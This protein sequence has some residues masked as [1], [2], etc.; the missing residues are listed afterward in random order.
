MQREQRGSRHAVLQPATA[1]DHS[2]DTDRRAS[3]M[4]VR[5]SDRVSRPMWT[6]RMSPLI[7]LRRRDSSLLALR[8][9][10]RTALVVPALL[11]LGI[12]VIHDTEVATFAVFGSFAMLMMVDFPGPVRARVQAEAGLAVA[13]GALV[14]AGTLVSRSTV[15]AVIAMALVGF[16]LLYAGIVSSVLAGATTSLLLAFILPVSLSAPPSAIPERLA[17]WG[18]AAVAALLAVAL[19]WP[20][21]AHDHVRGA[22]IAACRAL[23]RRLH[24]HVGY[25]VGTVAEGE[26]EAAVAEADAAVEA[27]QS[28]FLQTP[29]RPTG[30][31]TSARAVVRLVDELRWLSTIVHRASPRVALDRS[32]VAV[33]T[34]TAT[35]LERSADLLDA[36]REDPAAVDAAVGGLRSRLTDLRRS[37]TRQLPLNDARDGGAA[38]DA[39]LERLVSATDPSFRAQE[40][41]FVV[42]QVA[43]NIEL[44]AA[45]E[46]RTWLEQLLGRPPAGAV[47]ALSTARERAASA[48]RRDSV[49]LQNSVRGAVG[50]AVA[51]GVASA[52]EVQHSFWVVLATLSVLRSSALGTGQNAVRGLLG[53]TVGFAVGAALVVLIGTD[54]A[55]LW[56]LLPPAVLLAGLAPANVSFAAGQAA[57]TL[58]LLILFNILAPAGWQIGLVRIEDIALGGAVSVAVGLLFW[59]RGAGG[60][61]GS[62][63]AAAYR[64][65]ADYLAG[66]VRFGIGRPHADAP[67]PG[68]PTDEA[69]RAAAAARRLDDALRTFLSERGAKP[70]PLAEV[71]SLATGVVALRL[72]GDAVLDLWGGA[73]RTDGDR[74]AARGLVLTSTEQMLDWYHAFATSLTAADGVPEPSPPDRVAA[75]RLVV[76]LGRDLDRRDDGATATAVQIVWTGDQ[77]DAARRLQ[78]MI[79]GP[80]EIAVRRHALGRARARRSGP[81]PR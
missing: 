75:R 39:P 11:G 60:A 24:T 69:T 41:S 76:A 70:V 50:L 49:W 4:I 45:A 12:E 57:F 2:A 34:A 37:A 53:T 8:R 20:A 22:A 73:E 10:A 68:A 74:T 63:L 56:A 35:L 64:D 67:A 27:L 46:R 44:A 9:A 31:S 32:T 36:P 48:L 58:T 71:T 79:I 23:A 47:G 1:S 61:L 14:C 62:A 55:V 7:W 3:G 51:V 28:G 52:T 81:P 78:A 40:L 6:S 21:P 54:S 80:A 72:A 59:P 29:Y 26:R 16:S 15:L 30:L 17:G 5:A 18:L 19:L 38:A 25:V 13:G 66:A 42:L 33:T 65:S 43:S 77:V